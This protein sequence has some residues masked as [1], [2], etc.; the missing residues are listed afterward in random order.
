[1][2]NLVVV[3]LT[4]SRVSLQSLDD[5]LPEVRKSSTAAL[6]ELVVVNQPAAPVPPASQTSIEP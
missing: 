1:M 4:V 5:A 6:A 2:S 3:L